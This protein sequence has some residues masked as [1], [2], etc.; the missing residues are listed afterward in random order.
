[1]AYMVHPKY[2]VFNFTP[3]VRKDVQQKLLNNYEQ[4]NDERTDS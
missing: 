1:V 3:F 4:K 2:G